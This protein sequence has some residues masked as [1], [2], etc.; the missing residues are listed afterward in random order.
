M[1]YSI[2][3]ILPVLNEIKSLT[4]T[5]KILNKINMRKEYCYFSKD[6][7]ENKVKQNIYSLKKNKNFKCYSQLRPF[8]G[9]AIDLGLLKLKKIYSNYG[10]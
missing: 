9:G 8:V 1:K 7:T 10:I 6:L 4:K 5:I 3:I 2:S